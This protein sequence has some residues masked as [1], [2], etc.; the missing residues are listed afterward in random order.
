MRFLF[1][2]PPSRF[3]AV[4]IVAGRIPRHFVLRHLSIYRRCFH[5]PSLSLACPP[6]LPPHAHLISRP[7]RG[8]LPEPTSTGR[9]WSR[10]RD[11]LTMAT[12]TL[13]CLGR[14]RGGPARPRPP[15]MLRASTAATRSASGCVPPPARRRYCSHNAGGDAGPHLHPPA[16]AV[17][18]RRVVGQVHVLATSFPPSFPLHPYRTKRRATMTTQRADVLAPGRPNGTLGLTHPPHGPLADRVCPCL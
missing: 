9:C 12:S 2:P 4:T 1:R 7:A 17:S 8:G 14:N 13:A 11:H 16:R 6:C 10:R 5:S 3:E 15:N 18:C